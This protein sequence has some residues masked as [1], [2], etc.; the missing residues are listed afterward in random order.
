MMLYI[1]HASSTRWSAYSPESQCNARPTED[2]GWI[3][4]RMKESLQRSSLRDCWG[5]SLEYKHVAYFGL[6]YWSIVDHIA[7]SCSLSA[8]CYKGI[9]IKITIIIATT[10]II[11]RTNI[12]CSGP[13]WFVGWGLRSGARLAR[14]HNSQ[15]GRH[16]HQC[17]RLAGAVFTF[18]NVIV[19]ISL[20]KSTII[21]EDIF[22]S[23]KISRLGQPEVAASIFRAAGNFITLDIERSF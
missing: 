18:V 19:I 2:H 5:L 14:L 10:I 6:L 4:S 21:L 11:T 9:F 20:F 12:T 3:F 16:H 1:T 22:S 7:S 8:S 17:Q 23:P 15:A 13:K